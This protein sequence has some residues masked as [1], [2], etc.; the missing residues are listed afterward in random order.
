[1]NHTPTEVIASVEQ[2]ASHV[3][4][5]PNDPMRK[6]VAAVLAMATAWHMHNEA[7]L[8]ATEMVPCTITERARAEKAWDDAEDKATAALSAAGVGGGE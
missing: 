4:T 1:M 7:L 2:W 6:D 8:R 5:Q 3:I